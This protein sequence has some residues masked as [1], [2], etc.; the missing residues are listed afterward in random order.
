MPGTM[1][2][3]DNIKLINSDIYVDLKKKEQDIEH[4]KASLE[5][6]HSSLKDLTLKFNK[7]QEDFKTSQQTN[8][9]LQKDLDATKKDLAETST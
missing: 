1:A 6:A 2:S 8:N 5:I 7:L 4:L 3:A 9:N